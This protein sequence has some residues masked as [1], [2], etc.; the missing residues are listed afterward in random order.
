MQRDLSS[1]DNRWSL[2]QERFWEIP[3]ASYLLWCRGEHLLKSS[4]S[5]ERRKDVERW[6]R[7]MWSDYVSWFHLSACLLQRVG[8]MWR[9][10]ISPLLSWTLLQREIPEEERSI[11]PSL[12]PPP[13]SPSSLST[14]LSF[15]NL[16][17]WFLGILI[18]QFFEDLFF[19]FPSLKFFWEGAKNFYFWL[20]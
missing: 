5:L 9:E 2:T 7:D 12:S 19:N 10:M 14:P 16:V 18:G 3:S 11:F 1:S 15:G 17:V 8:K 6:C 4:H 20:G 13:T